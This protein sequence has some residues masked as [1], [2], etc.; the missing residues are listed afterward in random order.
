MQECFLKA[1]GIINNIIVALSAVTVSIIGLLGLRQW[2]KVLKGKTQFDLARRLALLAFE[3]KDQ[4][5]A[6][7]NVGTFRGEYTNRK[8]D[9]KESK[10]EKSNLDEWYAR[11]KRMESLHDIVK[12]LHEASWEASI[13]FDKKAPQLI[14]PLEASYKDLLVSFQTYFNFQI[15]PDRFNQDADWFKKHHYKVYGWPGDEIG[16]HVDSAVQ[17]FVEYL[18]TYIK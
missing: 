8:R 11:R 10:E 12:K 1:T 14:Q 4:F 18:S 13:L 16:K 3:F 6:T 9:E 2:R 7:R 15:K 5:H 17:T